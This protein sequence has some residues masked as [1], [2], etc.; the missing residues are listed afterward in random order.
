VLNRLANKVVRQ[1]SG[2]GRLPDVPAHELPAVAERR[3]DACVIGGGPAGLAAA[4]ACARRG[5]ATL[6][7]DDQLRPGG[8]LR[9]DPRTGR[10]HALARCEGATGAGVE[11]LARATAIGYFPEDDGGVLAVAASDQLVRVHAR[12]WIWA[13]GGYTVNLPF[14]DND[15]PGVIAARA[16]GRLLVDHGIVA[17]DKVCIVEVARVADD[18]SALAAELGRAGSD[19]TRIALADTLGARGRSWVSAIDSTRGR[20]DCDVVAVAAIPSPASE[21]PRQMGCKVMLEADAGGFRVV[22]DATGRTSTAG[23]WACGDVTGYMASTQRRRWRRIHAWQ[24]RSSC[25]AAKT[26]RSTISSTASSAATATSR[27]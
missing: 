2:L 19:V 27:R 17:G 1:L 6:L 9:A 15:R 11:L 14:P 7:I 25:A 20:I 10:A 21:G 8:S 23:V 18:A 3:V 5:L 24:R 4:T 22:V 16:I 26:S 13:T 12:G